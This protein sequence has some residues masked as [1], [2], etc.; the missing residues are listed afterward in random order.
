M[1]FI[2]SLKMR[3]VVWVWNHTPT[4]AEMSRLASESL[5]RTLP[6]S[7]RFKMRLHHVICVWCKRYR[8]HLQFLHSTAPRFNDRFGDLPGIRGLT[9]E[10]RQRILKR[11]QDAVKQ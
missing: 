6:M 4:C 2:E 7:T 10:A 1:K 5:E 9:H 11:I 3:W 8:V